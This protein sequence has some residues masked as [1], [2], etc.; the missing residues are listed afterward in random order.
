MRPRLTSIRWM[1]CSAGWTAL[2]FMTRENPCGFKAG[3]LPCPGWRSLI[4][5]RVPV[6][7]LYRRPFARAFDIGDRGHNSDIAQQLDLSIAQLNSRDDQLAG[8]DALQLLGLGVDLTG[9]R[10][11]DEVVGEQLVHSGGIPGELRHAPLLLQSFHLSLGIVFF[12]VRPLAG[13]G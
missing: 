1:R 10:D 8:A 12:L 9:H 3:D 13:E 7:A 2:L 4:D 6:L 5:T 11:A